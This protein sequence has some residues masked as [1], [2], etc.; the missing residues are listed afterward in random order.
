MHAVSKEWQENMWVI[1]SKIISKEKD[2]SKN[3]CIISPQYLLFYADKSILR[4]VI[5]LVRLMH[6][7]YSNHSG[8]NERPTLPVLNGLPS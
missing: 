6:A 3:L 1:A 4:A 2:I 7:L 8:Y 5:R